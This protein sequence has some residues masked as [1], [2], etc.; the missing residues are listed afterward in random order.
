MAQTGQDALDHELRRWMRPD[1][2]R[3]WK[4]GHE[5]DPI[6]KEYERIERKFS[7]DQPRVPAGSREGGQWTGGQAGG[8]ESQGSSANGSGSDSVDAQFRTFLEKSRQLAAAGKS[9]YQRCSDLCYPL[10]ER[11]Q[12]AGS[13]RN[14]FDFYKC[15]NVCLG[16][17]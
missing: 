11:F 7:P 10:L 6:Y 8:S 17:N 15:L 2:R 12:P 9:A 5:N 4:P 14:T 1:W 3:W 13:D 16:K